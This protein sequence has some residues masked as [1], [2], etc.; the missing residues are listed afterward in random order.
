VLS[1]LIKR[2]NREVRTI[3]TADLDIGIQAMTAS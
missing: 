1:G 2:V 3:T